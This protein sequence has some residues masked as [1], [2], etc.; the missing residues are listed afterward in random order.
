MDGAMAQFLTLIDSDIGD[1]D[2]SLVCRNIASI[3]EKNEQFEEAMQWYDQGVAL[4]EPHR[5]VVIRE[6]RAIFLLERGRASDALADYEQMLE[7]TSLMEIERER[8]RINAKL[9]REQISSI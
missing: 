5:R 3:L 2:K 1:L 8:F 9:L 6:Y 7:S 4:E